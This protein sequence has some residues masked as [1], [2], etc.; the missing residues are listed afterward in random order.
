MRGERENDKEGEGGRERERESGECLGTIE[1][2]V[3]R[4]PNQFPISVPRGQCYKTFY[5]RKL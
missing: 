4:F 1:I 3:T 2:V 5:G